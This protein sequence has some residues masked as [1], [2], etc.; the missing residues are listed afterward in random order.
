MALDRIRPH[1]VWG[2]HGELSALGAEGNLSERT[3]PTAPHLCPS[4]PGSF[5]AR[6]AH[7]LIPVPAPSPLQHLQAL[8]GLSLLM[9]RC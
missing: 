2:A 6:A 8:P 5:L 4:L 3:D 1:A 7:G 9:P